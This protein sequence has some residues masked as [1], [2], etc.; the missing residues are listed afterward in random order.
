E[1]YGNIKLGKCA[2]AFLAAPTTVQLFEPTDPTKDALTKKVATNGNGQGN[3]HGHNGNG[4]HLAHD[5]VLYDA[6]LALRD[7]VA[8]KKKLHPYLIFLD[9][10]IEEM[11]I[12]YPTTKDE[13]EHLT[14]VGKGK[15]MKYGKQFLEL[16]QQYV[17]DNDIQRPE[18]VIV[19][20]AANNNMDK[21]FII[22]QIDRRTPLD[23]IAD[24]KGISLDTVIERIEQIVYSGSRLNIGYYVDR[25][26]DAEVR[27]EIY[28]YFMETPT[29]CLREAE[30][31]LGNDYT[32]E[33]IQLVRAQ[34]YS[35]VAN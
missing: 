8:K 14:G 1:D 22:Q 29:D 32:R 21:L 16:I 6:L 11:A 7:K 5:P 31:E 24:M 23:E 27:E 3:G 18:D 9:T 19:K 13:L 26:V 17:D 20:H 15:V 4:Q 28:Q 25:V 10:S 30:K 34:F 35:E 12:K 33:E 2:E